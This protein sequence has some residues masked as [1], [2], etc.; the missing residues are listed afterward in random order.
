MNENPVSA[1]DDE[2]EAISVVYGALKGLEGPAQKRVVNYV[3][4][5]LNINKEFAASTAK[6]SPEETSEDVETATPPEFVNDH[7]HGPSGQKEALEGVSPVAQK[8]M[9]RNGLEP[10]LL[11][12]IFSL[13]VDEIDLV[14]KTVPGKS[15]RVRM[16]NVLLLKGAAAYLSG[17]V[18]RFTH[19][20]VKEIS[21]HYDAYDGPNFAAY[22][23]SF[24]ADVSGSKESGYSL[25]ARGLTNATELVKEMTKVKE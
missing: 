10:H 4:D 2:I 14:A 8:W 21:S 6:S 12:S 20:Q 15:K 19:Q 24:A 7:F 22:L 13:G 1:K 11:G 17:G 9:R 5:K 16:H 25:T 3:T 23:K 18:A